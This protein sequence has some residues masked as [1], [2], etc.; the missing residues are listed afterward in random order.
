MWDLRLL[1]LVLFG[2]AAAVPLSIALAEPFALAGV[3]LWAYGL[4]RRR[5]AAP[6]RSPYFWP[7][8]LFAAIA[9]ATS[10]LGVR[11]AHSCARCYRILML[12]LVFAYP[13][14]FGAGDADA[15]RGAVRAAV[16]FVAATTARAVYDVGR[17]AVELG[18]GTDLYDTGNMRDPQMYM[19]SLCLLAAFLATRPGARRPALI[20][21][22]VVA[23]AI[24]LVLHF[25]RGVWFAFMLAVT[26][27]ALLARRWRVVAAVAVAAA[28]VL[29]LPQTR[30]RLAALNKEWSAD[31]GGRYVLWTQVAPA[32]LKEY[33]W[34]MGLR[35]PSHEDF[36]K[37]AERLQPHLEHLHNNVLE[38]ALELGWA[39]L[40][41]WIWWMVVVLVVFFGAWRAG[42]EGAWLALGGLAAFAGLLLNGVVEYNFGDSEILMAA[43]L[44]MGLS[45][46]IREPTRSVGGAASR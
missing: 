20:P 45:G 3:L 41:V 10:V 38:I 43:C 33:P 4:V 31:T 32:M 19:I 40:A 17:V 8:V 18:R 27:I 24:G 12:G 34:G 26:G 21:A 39:G 35:G 5:G 29:A 23:N 13:A 42:G 36:A 11:P 6:L 2:F 9:L 28:A 37:H 46:V 44:L 30:Q 1:R 7:V 14:A 15:L 16:L 25:K 22:A